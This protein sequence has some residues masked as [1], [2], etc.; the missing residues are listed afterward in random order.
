MNP[1]GFK[2]MTLPQRRHLLVKSKTFG[3]D[4]LVDAVLTVT[5]DGSESMAASKYEG[6]KML[7]LSNVKRN[8]LDAA[9]IAT[10]DV[11]DVSKTLDIP[12]E[13]VS[14]YRDFFFDVKGFNRLSKLALI[15]DYD[16]E[17]KDLLVWALASGT[18]FLKWR[19]GETVSIN[20]IEGLKE[21]FSLSIY[22]AKEAAFSSSGSAT[23]AEAHKWSSS[24]TSLARLLKM[25]LL[26]S[27]AAK[28]DIE[29]ALSSI[30]PN[31]GSFANLDSLDDLDPLS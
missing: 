27:G 20:P 14:V 15:E 31:F 18:V 26:D 7:W 4:P 2:L 19:L 30:A 28:K 29:L 5:E 17:G 23:S 3:A 1:S 13:V 10:D 9:L 8:Y 12:A 21:L 24:A 25:Y 16:A 22:K 11:D 6:A